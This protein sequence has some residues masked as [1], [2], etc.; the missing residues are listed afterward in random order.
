M[1]SEQPD[2]R[3]TECIACL[4]PIRLDASMCHHCGSSQKHDPWKRMTIILKWIGGVVTVISLLIGMVTLTGYYQD[5][6]E[7]HNAVAELVDA[8][9]WLIKTK[10]YSQ[11]WQMYEEA[12]QLIPS[13][14]KAFRG[15]LQLSKIWLRDFRVSKETAE[16]VLNHI[17]AVLYR[18]LRKADD[19]ELATILAHVGKVQTIRAENSLPVYIDIDAIFQE[20]LRASPD[21]VYANAMMGY[22]ILVRRGVSTQDIILAQSK[23]AVALK[24]QDERTFV[25][26]LQFSSLV[27]HSYGRADEVEQAALGVLLR[28]SFSMMQNGEPKP[29]ERFRFKILDAYGMMGRAEHIEASISFLPP[30]DH[31]AVQKWLMDGLDYSRERMLTQVLYLRA[32][33]TEALGKEQ[34]A[35]EQYQSLLEISNSTKQLDDLVNKGI[36]RLTGELPERALARTYFDDP[37]DEN[38]PWNFHIGT[39]AHFDPKWQPVN[40]DQ[41]LEYFENAVAQSH[42]K[43][44]VLV[45]IIPKELDRIRKVVREG[46]EIARSNSYTSGFN[47][48]HH[49]N[50]RF[51]ILRLTY[52]YARALTAVGKL[53]K[54]IA[55]LGDM[56]KLTDKIDDDWT[57]ARAWMAFELAR[58]YAIRADSKENDMDSVNA[59]KYLRMSVEGDG[60]NGE[61]TTWDEIKSDTFRSIWDDPDY[62]ELIQGR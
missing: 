55:E 24:S 27:S 26:R 50:A 33:L 1:T 46:N 11:A 39:L 15:Q 43:L 2:N 52:I 48:F 10:Y 28:E 59:V 51:N 13:S 40:F 34:E 23:F 18:G 47:K 16:E 4:E 31:L 61:I 7:R 62:K 41:A 19:Y 21:N 56:K 6:R 42:E 57:E 35:L 44:P 3:N 32:R 29:T 14:A 49:E 45:N 36:G 17:T 5:W 38:D 30:A 54:A 58:A 22:W 12:L 20:A 9:D 8:A 60:V 53:D 37:I 25:R